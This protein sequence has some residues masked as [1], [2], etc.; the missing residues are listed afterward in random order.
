MKV[1]ISK[2]AEI[3]GV[4][5]TTLRR[6]D[7]EGKLKAE[8]TPAGHRRY[9][10]RKLNQLL[11][12]RNMANNAARYT[13]LYARVTSSQQRPQLEQQV[14]LLS[15]YCDT[16]Q[17]DFEVV[18]DIGSGVNGRLPGL[19]ELIQLICSGDVERLVIVNQDRL[20]RLGAE[21]IFALCAE[22][23]VEIVISNQHVEGLERATELNRDVEDI[24]NIFGARLYDQYDGRNG[25]NREAL[26]EL[27]KQL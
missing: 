27:A 4:S 5:I 22:F 15:N 12:R 6:W 3:L 25:R 21:L 10:V 26:R 1:S 11:R 19:R 2:A 8:R 17:W 14:K 9:D 13:V 18:S 16:H 20:M 23:G 7:A 24:L